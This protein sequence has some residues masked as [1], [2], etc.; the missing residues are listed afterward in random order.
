ML[1][2]RADFRKCNWPFLKSEASKKLKD[3][4]FFSSTGSFQHITSLWC[5]QSHTFYSYSNEFVETDCMWAC[6]CENWWLSY[7]RWRWLSCLQC[8]SQTSDWCVRGF[9]SDVEGVCIQLFHHGSATGCNASRHTSWKV[10]QLLLLVSFPVM[11]YWALWILSV[12]S[13]SIK[14]LRVPG[15]SP[16]IWIMAQKIILTNILYDG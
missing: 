11:L 5:Q 13:N 9:R 16:T 4:L 14:T 12:S 7:L 10:C 15:S 8:I 1:S 3:G 6:A 2:Q